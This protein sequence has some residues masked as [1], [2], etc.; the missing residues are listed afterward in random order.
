MKTS[1][2]L[3]I[4]TAFL[5]SAFSQR[6]A[7]T[8]LLSMN[9]EQQGVYFY[10]KARKQN[11]TGWIMLGSG[12]AGLVAGSAVAFDSWG[13]SNNS[14]EI[15]G[16]IIVTA[17]T[18]AMIGSVVSFINA[19]NSKGKGE[20]L[21]RKP[22]RAEGPEVEK[23]LGMMYLRKHKTLRLVGWSLV[24]TGLITSLIAGQQY[25]SEVLGTVSWLASAASIPVFIASSRNK[26]RASVLFNT[27]R[28]PFSYLAS[29]I[30]LTSVGVGITLG[31]TR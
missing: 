7:D 27:Q 16:L 30:P 2:F 14:S 29:P 22:A 23:D 13:S 6:L 26:G 8:A 3:L 20:M 9:R 19:A 28:I 31:S 4:M 18:V 1:I 15:A 12:F 21:L 17:S 24:G 10:S 25:N 11:T 5:S